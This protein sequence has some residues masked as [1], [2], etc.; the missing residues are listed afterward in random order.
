LVSECIITLVVPTSLCTAKWHENTANY[1]S[2]WIH[3]CCLQEEWL[4]RYV[5]RI[6]S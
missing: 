3:F 4:V 6:L 1:Y 5:F 2:K